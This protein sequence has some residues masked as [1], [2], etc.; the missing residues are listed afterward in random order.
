MCLEIRLLVGQA[1]YVLCFLLEESNC[2]V[3]E[4]WDN[5]FQKHTLKQ[6]IDQN[7]SLKKQI[8]TKNK[9]LEWII[10][11]GGGADVMLG[12]MID[13]SRNAVMNVESIKHFVDLLVKMGY[14]TLMLYTEDTFEVN[15]QPFFGHKRGRYTKEELKDI[16]RYCKSKGV[17]LIPC[18]QTLAHLNCVFKWYDSYNDMNDCDDILLIGEEKT[19]QLIQDMFATISECFTS[20]QIHIGMDEAHMVGL[21]KYL[22]KHG[23]EERF[24]VIN[25]HLHK[26]CA[27]AEKFELKPMIWSD[28]FC[29][30][31]MGNSDYYDAENV[32]VIK[33]QGALPDRVSLVYWD[34]YG[35]DYE[36]YKNLIKANQAFGREVVFA[37]GAWTWKGFLPDNRF[38]IETM[39]PAIQACKDCGVD[40]IVFTLWG[41]DGGECSR[42]GVLPTLFY[43]SQLV[44]GNNNVE[45]IKQKFKE[46]IGMDFD[47]FMLLEEMDYLGNGHLKKGCE[48]PSKYL[49][50]N[51]PFLGLMDYRLSGC[52]NQYY[53]DMLEKLSQLEIT[54]EYEVIFNYAK[55]LCDVLTVKSELGLRTRTLYLNKDKK[56]LRQL[57][58]TEYN[59]AIEKIMNFHKVYQIWWTNENKPQGFEVQDI[60]IGG[61]LQRIRSCRERILAY[62]DGKIDGIP[63]LEEPVLEDDCGCTWARIVTPGVL[64]HL[65]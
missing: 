42:Y 64:S 9:D 7:I 65:V 41:D 45:D 20:K 4:Y 59:Q 43:T 18:I 31:A 51:D 11:N 6:K 19:Y 49:L 39:T 48:A 23:Y 58:E 24:N 30:L 29:K 53:S 2:S 46:T 38:S 54:K 26:V 12:V 22:Q 3:M 60:R 35:K 44:S 63:E 28:M 61:L 33:T 25:R 10:L 34:Y 27:L 15:N 62:C 37:G 57:A 5:I 36:R 16:D 52:E 47:S 32:E 55:K 21:G 8:R 17:E 14:D 40:N 50:Y 1:L 56:L 13:C